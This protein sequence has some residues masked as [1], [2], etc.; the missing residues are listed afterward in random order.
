MKEKGRDWGTQANSGLQYLPKEK[1]K[2]KSSTWK[3]ERKL[4]PSEM[5]GEGAAKQKE[6]DIKSRQHME[7][8]QMER[9]GSE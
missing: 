6:M 8:K 2:G 1:I 9:Q 7:Q 3:R 5:T 4:K